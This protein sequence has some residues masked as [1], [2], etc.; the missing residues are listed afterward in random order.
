[1]DSRKI[2]MEYIP[3]A[4]VNGNPVKFGKIRGYKAQI[5]NQETGELVLEVLR[6]VFYTHPDTQE[7]LL[8]VVES[9]VVCRAE[10]G[11]IN[12]PAIALLQTAQEN[13]S[14]ICKRT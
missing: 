9:D 5:S 13:V 1:M 8:L 10:K 12:Y 6:E 4:F 14:R 2:K 11:D 3:C 7:A